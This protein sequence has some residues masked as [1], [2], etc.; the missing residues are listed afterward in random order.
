MDLSVARDAVEVAVDLW[1]VTL[2]LVSAVLASTIAS[3]RQGRLSFRYAVLSFLPFLCTAAIVLCGVMFNS[4]GAGLPVS[5]RLPHILILVLLISQ[6]L[7]SGV[8]M[9]RM[10]ACFKFVVAVSA[11][12]FWL[13][14]GAGFVGVMSVNGD[15]L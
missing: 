9:L 6:V 3:A 2:I 5:V 10:R 1:P 14:L 8:L 13:S 11:L 12:A 7:L 4:R 15:W